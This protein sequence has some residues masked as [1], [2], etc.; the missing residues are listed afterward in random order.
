MLQREVVLRANANNQVKTARNLADKPGVR[1]GVMDVY[2]PARP[3]PTGGFPAVI[4]VHGG[5]I[6]ALPGSIKDIGQYRSY[7]R[8]IASRGLAAVT[9][10]FRFPDLAGLSTASADVSDALAY[11]RAHAAEQRLDADRLCLWVVSGGGVV[12]APLL[13]R[14]A[15]YVRCW[16]FYYTVLN[17][18]AFGQLG[19]PVPSDLKL[20]TYS[21]ADAVRT[22]GAQLPPLLVVRAGQDAPP[23]NASLDALVAAALEAGAALDFY[24]HPTGPHAFDVLDDSP[25]TRAILESSLAFVRRHLLPSTP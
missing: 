10:A 11:I 21:A 4:F 15:P 8:L 13:T 18:T 12:V 24:A 19:M 2:T 9:F 14:D 7:G 5:P 20:E 6:P 17:V 23:I 25:R 3:A 22:R 1:E 16:V